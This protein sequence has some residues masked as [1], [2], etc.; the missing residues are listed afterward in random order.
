MR[1]QLSQF[2]IDP[3]HPNEMRNLRQS[4]LL[5]AFLFS[6]ILIFSVFDAIS[7]LTIPGYQVP[8][9]GYICLFGAYGLNRLAFYRISSVLCVFM[10]PAVVFASILS[11]ESA[12]P[13][14]SLSFLLVGLVVA[15]LFISRWGVVILAL[16]DVVGVLLLPRFAP[17]FMTEM[18]SIIILLSAIVVGAVLILISSRHRDQVEADRQALLRQ[19]EER[20]RMLFEEAP[21]GICIVDLDNKIIMINTVLCILLGYQQGEMLGRSVVDFIDPEDL[22]RHPPR[23][24]SQ[25]MHLGPLKRERVLVRKDGIPLNAIVSS[26]FMPDG[27]LQYIVQDVTERKKMEDAIRASEEK[28][29]KAFQSGPDAIT[30]SSIE[31]GKFIDVNEGFCIMSEYTREE[32]IGRSA[33]DLGIWDDVE[34]R[35][36][37]VAILQRDGRVREFETLLK[38]RSGAPVNCLLSVEK[39]EIGNELCMVVV[40]RDITEKKRIEQERE[41]LLQELEAKNVELEQFAYTVSHDLKA[42]L[43]TIKGFLGLLA[44]DARAGKLQRLESD[45]HR[46]SEASDK[47]HTL[48]NDLLELSRIGRLMNEPENVDCNLLVN[49][50]KKVLTGTL[51]GLDVRLQINGRLPI[52]KGDRQ[53]LSEVF[54]N[55]VDNAA[56][57]MG[58]Q[59]EPTI[60]IGAQ[61]DGKSGLVTLYVRDNGIGIPAQHHDRIFG[62]FNRLNPNVDGTG[63]GLALVKRIVEFH[64]GNIWVES[65]PGVGSTFF[66]TL[67]HVN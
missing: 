64:G 63:V 32:A 62:L 51:E 46:I 12:E 56:K 14:V 57:F 8:W 20:Y 49:E 47:M 21:D 42:P 45:I 15:E 11:G 24:I 43:I 44:E 13:V 52:I 53:R 10:F 36:T 17:Q 19:S 40:T 23:Q 28:F 16:A 30:I 29:A 38:R 65:E 25:I 18:D 54:Q 48:L 33:E 55:L 34:Q 41:R 1:Q 4:R 37:M 35:K 39:I 67:P 3:I 7:I 22:V 5:S 59:T 66:F 26:S 6:M 58:D 50:V 61:T 31:T 27:H 9:Y 2:L 60:E